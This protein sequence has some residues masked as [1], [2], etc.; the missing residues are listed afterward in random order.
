[1][2]SPLQHT[3]IFFSNTRNLLLI[4]VPSL[5]AYIAFVV[6]YRLWIS[7][8]ATIPGPW[9]AAISDFWLTTHV[10]R[11]QQCKIIH[12]LFELYGPVVRV[13]PNK[14]VFRDTNTMR[15]VYTVHKFDKSSYYKSL[16]TNNNDHA[17]TTLEHAPHAIR[18]KAYAT[19]YNLANLSL[20]QPEMHDSAL[21]V[22]TT[23]DVI[24]ASRSVDC[25][26]LFRQMMVDVVCAS[27]FGQGA[28]ALARWAVDGEGFLAMAINDFPKRGILRSKVPTWA[29]KL[30]C[31][32]PNRKFQR[33]C[34]SDKILADFV[35]AKV[36]ETS[37]H[38]TSGKV[39][40]SD[41]VPLLHRLL[42]YRVAPS[43]DLMSER[44]IISEC[45]GHLIAGSDTTSI[46][47]SYIFW[48]LSR[49]RDIAKKLQD[50]L[51]E[52]MTD[53]RV[54]PEISVL[55]GLPYLNALI[56]E[57][58]RLYGAGPSLLERVVP[59]GKKGAIDEAF[60]LMGYALPPGTIVATQAW[61]LH[62]DAAVFASPE[63]FLPDRWLDGN[64][65][66]MAQ[67]LM[68]FGTG[69]R[70]CGGQNL[71]HL[72]LKITIA[73]VARNFVVSAPPQT[74]E[75]SM[76]IKDSFVIFPAAM[77]CQLVFHPRAH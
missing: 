8:L 18:R 60:D 15:S 29:W 52:A 73:A 40:D 66:R 16:L 58:F 32:I 74:T 26:A 23:L 76:E 13:G 25:L 17:M 42:R 67:H 69:S 4:A 75:R 6:I 31:S 46:T 57:G 24:A 63:T 68:P 21:E 39:D 43:N 44:D 53:P 41:K 61:S 48:E 3:I 77:A 45:M 35:T 19:H 20:F 51:D 5:V 47:L 30:V 72:M 56:K 62:R 49:R 12:Q 71:A 28:G 22:L 7:H 54:I 59:S 11:L 36:F 38:I 50:E 33:L 70:V 37:S 55:Q 64:D 34:D 65:A 27:S 10:V 9:Y 2:H 14:V 1:M